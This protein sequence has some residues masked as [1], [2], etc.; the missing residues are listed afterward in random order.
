[1]IAT[2][3]LLTSAATAARGTAIAELSLRCAVPLYGY[4][5]HLHS[6]CLRETRGV[7]ARK[8]TMALPNSHFTAVLLSSRRAASW[9]A[10]RDAFT[11]AFRSLAN[12]VALERGR[13]SGAVS[14]RERVGAALQVRQAVK[15]GKVA[16]I[17]FLMGA[18]D[19]F[20]V[21]QE[22]S[23]TRVCR[24][25]RCHIRYRREGAGDSLGGA[26]VNGQ[27]R[28]PSKPLP[29]AAGRRFEVAVCLE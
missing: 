29:M 8:V 10:R 2:L 21:E 22:A 18:A 7:A 23:L 19:V 28:K 27:L 3:R 15:P 16:R 20:K 24:G 14:S 11:G 4:E 25:S 17:D 9:E 6:V 26:Q 12:P 5:S 13:C 1:M